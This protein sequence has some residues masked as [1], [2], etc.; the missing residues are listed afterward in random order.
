MARELVRGPMLIKLQS[1]PH[2]ARPGAV[3]CFAPASRPCFQRRVVEGVTDCYRCTSH[4]VSLVTWCPSLSQKVRSPSPASDAPAVGICLLSWLQSTG[5]VWGSKGFLEDFLRPH[6][7]QPAQPG[8]PTAMSYMLCSE[9][10]VLL[11]FAVLEAMCAL[12]HL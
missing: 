2:A 7:W 3:F 11:R 9:G 12:L 6:S 4:S 5:S 1:G 8:C 10:W